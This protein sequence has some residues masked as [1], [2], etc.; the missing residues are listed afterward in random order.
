MRVFFDTSSFVK[1]FV[2][3][4]GSQQADEITEQATE[5][6]LSI[7]CFPELVSALN[8]KLR[9]DLIDD[10]TYLAL[11]RDILEDIKDAQIINLTPSVIEETTGLLETNTLRSLDAIHIACALE[12]QAEVFVSSDER[13]VGAAHRAGLKIEYIEGVKPK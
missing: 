5:I 8:G 2:E 12:W 10:N 7:I 6:G 1:R 11:K 4:V 3:E 13:Q 9:S